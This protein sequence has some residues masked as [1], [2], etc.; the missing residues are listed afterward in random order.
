MTDLD[1]HIQAALTALDAALA[2]PHEDKGGHMLDF[3][4]AVEH[5]AIAAADDTAVQRFVVN[6]APKLNSAWREY[7][8]WLNILF[9]KLD[10]VVDNEWFCA[11]RSYRSQL[12]FLWQLFKDTEAR[13]TLDLGDD[14][15]EMNEEI[16]LQLD[17]FGG[18]EPPPGIPDS[19]WWWRGEPK[20]TLE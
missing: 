17:Y 15:A 18:H 10:T 11:G 4:N 1:R 13:E 6:T 5:I 8:E 19:H 14:I 12:E 2:A 9:G 7:A 20:P 16:L 3:M